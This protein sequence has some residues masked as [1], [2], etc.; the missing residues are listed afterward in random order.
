MFLAESV[1][2]IQQA[3]LNH[4]IIIWSPDIHE[5]NSAKVEASWDITSDSLAA[6]LANQLMAS[7]LILVKSA[8]IPSN[9]TVQEMQKQGLL[10]LAFNKYTKNSCYK[11]TLIN[12]Y[13]F[14]EY[15]LT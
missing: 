2:A 1:S 3:L 15:P 8:E 4:S 14:N 6:W 5:L 9:A 7:E 12:K 13:R 11:I 10:D